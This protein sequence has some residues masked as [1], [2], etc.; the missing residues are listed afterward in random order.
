MRTPSAI[1]VRHVLSIS[2]SCNNRCRVCDAK[3]GRAVRPVLPVVRPGDLLQ[4]TGAEPTLVPGIFD[5]ARGAAGLGCLVTLFTNGRAFVYPENAAK[6]AAS[7]LSAVSITLHGITAGAHDSFTQ[8]PGS[9]AQTVAGIG[10]LRRAGVRV[11]IRLPARQSRAEACDLMDFAAALGARQV[12]FSVRDPSR[13]VFDRAAELDAARRAAARAPARL[14]VLVSYCG[15]DLSLAEPAG[16]AE[17]TFDASTGNV[18]AAPR[19]WCSNRCVFCT[20]KV[21]FGRHGLP[22]PLDTT[23]GFAAAIDKIAARTKRRGVF[24]FTTIEPAENP[25]LLEMAV[26]AR[27]AG[28]NRLDLWTHGRTLSDRGVARDLLR[29]G[30]RGFRI[31]IHGPDA[32][33][34]DLVA[35]SAGAFA[36]ALAGVDTLHALGGAEISFC[37]TLTAQNQDRLDDLGRFARARFGVECLP[38]ADARPSTSYPADFRGYACRLRRLARAIERSGVY[39]NATIGFMPP[40][41]F[42]DPAAHAAALAA[43]AGRRGIHIAWGR[44]GREDKEL[45]PCPKS[46]L[47]RWSD[48]CPGINPQYGALFGYAE[49]RPAPRGRH[50][51]K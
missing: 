20:A 6:A 38:V 15:L 17:L 19:N 32:A 10:H 29:A 26:I 13:S 28:Y 8:T 2:G 27:R 42:R 43:P 9:F 47:C 24:E 12:T 48:S 37:A 33:T 39:S 4:I 44:K 36:E 14:D 23:G 7:G 25:F 16:E 46:R 21:L 30:F 41:L 45:A 50:S 11:D 49:F 1:P 31:P 35:G 34:H 3:V 5:L 22:M 18:S 40:C 51:A